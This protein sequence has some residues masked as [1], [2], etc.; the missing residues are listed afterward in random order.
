MDKTNKSLLILIAIIIIG[1]LAFLYASSRNNDVNENNN[2]NAD[3][4]VDGDENEIRDVL[5]SQNRPQ[6]EIDVIFQEEYT[7]ED[8]LA[9]ESYLEENISDITA[10]E[11][12]LG[13]TFMIS[14]F[15][16]VNNST[17]VIV[18]EDGHNMYEAEVSLS[19]NESDE[20]SVEYFYDLSLEEEDNSS[21]KLQAEQ[22]EADAQQEMEIQILESEPIE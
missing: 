5:E 16:W 3:I 9:F 4:V 11:P 21:A 8:R 20:I 2:T 10:Q 15:N 19:Y 12:S 22:E 6:D 13:G 1:G 7:E 17:A 18:Y 14:S